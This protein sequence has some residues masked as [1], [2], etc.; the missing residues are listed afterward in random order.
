MRNCLLLLFLTICGCT[1]PGFYQG[2][3]GQPYQPI[4]W[5]SPVVNYRP[6]P[7]TTWGTVYSPRGPVMWNAISQ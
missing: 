2:V 4:I 1:S 3:A 5:Q 6:A 7:V